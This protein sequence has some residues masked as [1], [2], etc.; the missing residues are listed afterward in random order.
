MFHGW[1]REV[2]FLIFRKMDKKPTVEISRLQNEESGL[3]D[4]NTDSVY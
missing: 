1:S 3:R 4:C 2:G